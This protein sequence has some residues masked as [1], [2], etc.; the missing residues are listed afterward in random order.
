MGFE[1]GH[2]LSEFMLSMTDPYGFR[3]LSTPISLALSSPPISQALLP[4]SETSHLSEILFWPDAMPL[5]GFQAG[6]VATE[7]GEGDSLAS[8]LLQTLAGH[9]WPGRLWQP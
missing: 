5:L 4:C 9:V 8:L 6:A 1:P 7:G 3:H 2:P